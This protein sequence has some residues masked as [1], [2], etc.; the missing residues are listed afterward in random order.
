MFGKKK[1]RAERSFSMML[2][3]E[4]LRAELRKLFGDEVK[5]FQCDTEATTACKLKRGGCP[6]T[7]IEQEFHGADKERFVA[8]DAVIGPFERVFPDNPPEDK[9]RCARKVKAECRL[10]SIEG[11]C[12]F[13]RPHYLAFTVIDDRNHSTSHG[14]C[15]EEEV[16][17]PAEGGFSFLQSLGI[18]MNLNWEIV[19]NPCA[20]MCDSQIQPGTKVSA[21]NWGN[22]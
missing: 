6:P 8:I 2:A 16:S 20:G 10:F 5:F 4:L 19:Q 1:R 21:S 17:P 14:F 22:D 12:T 15:Y 3:E 18:L 11:G 13:W 9:R 7:R